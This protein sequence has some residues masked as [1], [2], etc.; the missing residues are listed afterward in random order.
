MNL[1]RQRLLANRSE[2]RHFLSRPH[3]RVRER[4]GDLP[5]FQKRSSRKLAFLQ[6]VLRCWN[7]Q[8]ECPKDYHD[9]EAPKSASRSADQ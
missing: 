3:Q 1:A 8:E 9:S 2:W 5:S 7:D 6:P 4:I